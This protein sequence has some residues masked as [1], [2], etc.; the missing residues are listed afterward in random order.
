MGWDHL[1]VV[2]VPGSNPCLGFFISFLRMESLKFLLV[3]A[4]NS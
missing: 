3:V 1:E 4:R 2:V